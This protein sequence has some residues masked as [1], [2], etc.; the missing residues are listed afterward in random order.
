MITQLFNYSTFTINLNRELKNCK[1]T[2]L[3]NTQQFSGIQFINELERFFDWLTNKTEIA[4][5]LVET[6]KDEFYL[7]GKNDL[8]CLNENAINDFLKRVQRV[9]WAQVVL[10]QTIIWN[11]KS[12]ID[13]L[14]LELAAGGDIR[15]CTPSFRMTF[16]IL[17]QGICPMSGGASLLARTTGHSILKS[18][19]MTGQTVNADNLIK[20]GIIHFVD[21]GEE[22]NTTLRR[23][24]KQSPIARIQFKRSVNDSL[25]VEI[26][27]VMSKELSF[28]KASLAIGD[29][30]RWSEDREFANPREYG[31]ILRNT[32][33]HA[34]VKERAMA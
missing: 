10:P 5:V 3:N 15:T 12:T 28:A 19:I 30:K 29:W 18:Y 25:I 13:F 21:H 32:P 8:K 6:E 33:T 23:I 31:K 27:E 4:S 1:I 22:T 16:D 2:V 11:F 14:T 20:H 26:D 34:D 17:S 24:S 7:I 9:S